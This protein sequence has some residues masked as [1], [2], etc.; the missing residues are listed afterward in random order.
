MGGGGREEPDPQALPSLL[1]C[2][3]EKLTDWPSSETQSLLEE[4][5]LLI[6]WFSHD[7]DFLHA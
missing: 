3:F 7:R 2:I 1:P 5:F 4:T 6:E